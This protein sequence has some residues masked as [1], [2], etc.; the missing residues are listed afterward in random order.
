MRRPET[1][2][3]FVLSLEEAGAELEGMVSSLRANSKLPAAEVEQ[4][5]EQVEAGG[6]AGGDA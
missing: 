6:G 3:E 1:R 4:V 5:I 2:W